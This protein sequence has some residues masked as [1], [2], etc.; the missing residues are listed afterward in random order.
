MRAQLTRRI[1]E[2]LAVTLLVHG[3]VGHLAAHG[4]GGS[5]ALAG[6]CGPGPEPHTGL[7]FVECFDGGPGRTLCICS[8]D[9]GVEC[10]IR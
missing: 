2:A 7:R 6:G 1:P 8:L 10:D 4:V 3:A 5:G 9:A